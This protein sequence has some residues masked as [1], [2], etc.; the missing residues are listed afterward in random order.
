VTDPTGAVRARFAPAPTGY[1]HIGGAR[2]AL[3]N[4]L[5]AR[6][7]GGELALR[8]E[9]T[10]AERSRPELVDAIY[11]TLG[12]LG[13]DWDG[14]PVHQSDRGDLYRAAAD[15]LLASGAAYRCDCTRAD[16]DAR[17]EANG[18]KTP[19]YDGF[20][21]DRDVAPGPDVVVRFR[22]PDP[23]GATSFDDMIRGEVTFEHANLEDFVV[24]RSGGVPMFLLANAIDDADMAITHIIRGE[25]LINTTPK[26]LLL[27]DALGYDYAPR[28]AHV[29]LIVNEK[30][31]KLSKRRDDVSVGDYRERGYLP[32]AMVNYLATLGWGA[33]DGVEIRP[34]A[35]IVE[36]FQVE[37][38][39]SSSAF[40][41]LKKLDHFAGDYIR[42]LPTAEFV[43]RAGPWLR[44]EVGPQPPWPPDAFDAAEFA[45]LAPLVQE[46]VVRL[47][48]V[49]GYVDFVFLPEPEVD[50]AAWDKVMV[51]AAGSA[52]L[53]LDAV[54]AEYETCDWDADV[55]MAVIQREGERLELPK[56]QWQAPVRVAVTG[57]S[58]GPPLGESLVVLGRERTLARLRAARGAL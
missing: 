19:G 41:D 52:T 3:F 23:D 32:E 36:L 54:I 40:F 13:L 34:L 46:R 11:E 31:Q 1:L 39:S 12:W 43:D 25:D 44:G 6:H 29:P 9:D 2:T 30:R 51:K 16:V 49:P 50:Q 38:V 35:E 22:I 20:C 57:R 21:R 4:W 10:D 17:N 37:D 27:R 47:D 8:V 18:R 24:V 28:Y 56:K 15:R 33:P 7:H 14:E 55:V 5:F 48:Q 42:A 53:M 45:A 58:V 26:V